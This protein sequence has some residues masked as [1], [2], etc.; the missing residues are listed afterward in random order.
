MHSETRARTTSGW[1]MLFA[2][3]L[4]LGSSLFVFVHGVR[5]AAPAEAIVGTLLFAL[6]VLVSVGFFIVNP[7]EAAVLLLFGKYVGTVKA[8][9]FFWVNPFIRRRKISLR[10]RNLNGEKL[11]VNDRAGNPIEIAAVLVWEVRN[12]AEAM[13]DVDDYEEITT[14]VG[15]LLGREG[16]PSEGDG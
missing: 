4:V 11:K 10:A 2:V 15:R 3:L 8:N 1:P 16:M 6:F 9:G 7:N 12:T 5:E 14:V 13:F